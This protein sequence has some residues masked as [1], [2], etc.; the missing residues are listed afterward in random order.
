MSRRQLFRLFAYVLLGIC[1]ILLL[2][3]YALYLSAQKL[4]DFYRKSLSVPEESHLLQHE[5]MRHKI[6]QL[7]NDL[8]RTEEKWEINVTDSDLNGFFAVESAKSENLFP[9]EI[10][11]PRLS[12]SKRQ[13][14]FAC[15]IEQGTV[16]GILHLSVQMTL[17][18][19]NRV[20]LRIKSAKLG[21]LPIS[22]KLPA[23]MLADALLKKEYDVQTDFDGDEP[24][25]TVTFDWKYAKKY[26]IE[27][28]ALSVQ[29]GVLQLSGSSKKEEK[30]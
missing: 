2:V 9:P 20:M 22:K 16:T 25:I 23:R 28:D 11:S 1:L 6:G 13:I 14:D 15:R 26:S 21:R 7:N 18:E 17:P 4:P 19:P 29:D 3:L 12:F 10:F 30:K 24:S 8:Q 27:L 5:R